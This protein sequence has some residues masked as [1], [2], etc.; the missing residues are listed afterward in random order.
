MARLYRSPRAKRDIADVLE[1]T[2]DRWGL[3]QARAYRDLI[4]EA[5]KSI[6]ADPKCGKVRGA[7]L[8]ILSHHI[9]LPGRNAR[10]VV[11]YQPRW[12]GRD[13]Q[14][15]SRL[16]GLRSASSLAQ[17][18]RFTARSLKLCSEPTLSLLLG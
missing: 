7:R 13:R 2:R 10:H 16:D 5:L 14:S 3:A 6:A 11:F 18:Q 15:P 1:Y 17:I 4:R 12:R 9:K 8:G